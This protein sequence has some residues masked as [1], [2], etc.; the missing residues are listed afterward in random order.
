MRLLV[1]EDGPDLNRQLTTALTEDGAHRPVLSARTSKRNRKITL[2][3]FDVMRQQKLEHIGRLLQKLRRLRKIPHILRHLRMLARQLPELR[4]KVRIRQKP[5]I[6]HHI[7]I[8]RHTIL[9]S[10][11]RH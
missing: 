2:A 4:N 7:R 8:R 6:E 5:H 11:A 9:E 3:F 1:V 10:E